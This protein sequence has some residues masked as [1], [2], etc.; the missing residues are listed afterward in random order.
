MM[1]LPIWDSDEAFNLTRDRGMRKMNKLHDSSHLE[2][3][4]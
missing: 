2:E 1:A 3:E 4:E